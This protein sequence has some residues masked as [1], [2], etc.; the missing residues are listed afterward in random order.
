MRGTQPISIITQNKEMREILHKLDKIS[1]SDSSVLLVG[2]TGVGKE[3]FA[4]YIH[5][6]SSRS[7][8]PIVKIGLSAMPSE[9]L[10]SELF[11]YEKG[12]FTNANEKKKGLFEVADT[13]SIFLD[14]IIVWKIDLTFY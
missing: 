7:L 14:D 1:M 6:L 8:N 12:A 10:S 13:G 3:I 5:K 9:L 4:D 2:E 11:G